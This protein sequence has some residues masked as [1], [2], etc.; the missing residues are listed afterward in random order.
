MCLQPFSSLHHCQNTCCQGGPSRVELKTMK[1]AWSQ[2]RAVRQVVKNIAGKSQSN[3][4]H[5]QWC[6][7][8]RWY[9]CIYV[10]I[11]CDNLAQQVIAFFV[12]TSQ[13]GQSTVQSS[14]F[15]GSLW[16]VLG[17]TK[18]TIFWSLSSDNCVQYWHWNL[19]KFR[20]QFILSW[21]FCPH[22]FL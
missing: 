15:C 22:E 21:I 18:R 16:W 4:G 14:F 2:V 17:S 20:G 12:V 1:T 5:R 3:P 19:R 7:V 9:P 8:L 6:V 10:W 11:A 13:K